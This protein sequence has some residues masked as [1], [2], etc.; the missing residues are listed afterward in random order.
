LNNGFL[1]GKIL[2]WKLKTDTLYSP[3]RHFKE[4]EVTLWPILHL[5][6]EENETQRDWRLKP[7]PPAFYLLIAGPLPCFKYVLLT[8]L[9]TL[10]QTLRSFIQ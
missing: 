2:F 10:G 6:D 8:S 4:F 1:L 3:Y 9:R 7:L 5:T